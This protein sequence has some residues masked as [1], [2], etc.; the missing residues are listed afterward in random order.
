MNF[1]DRFKEEMEGS[2]EKDEGYEESLEELKKD[3]LTEKPT[4]PL[5][6][7]DLLKPSIEKNNEDLLKMAAGMTDIIK[8]FHKELRG[9]ATPKRI[10]YYIDRFWDTFLKL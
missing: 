3:I 6:L 7:E 10:N 4:P 1:I 9:V 5:F 8:H 2:F